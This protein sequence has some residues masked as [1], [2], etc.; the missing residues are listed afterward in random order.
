MVRSDIPIEN[1]VMILVCQ[2][3][4]G[5]QTLRFDGYVPQNLY[6]DAAAAADHIVL[7]AHAFGLGACWLTHGPETHK[8]IREHFQLPET[9][10]SRCH[11]ILGWPAEAP[12]KSGKMTVDLSLIN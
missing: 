8:R 7:M 2:D 12:I 6:F 9:F 11:I 4:T 3:L 10:I 5:Y 1:A